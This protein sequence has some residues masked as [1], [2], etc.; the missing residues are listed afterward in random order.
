MKIYQNLRE[1][2]M[3]FN[4]VADHFYKKKILSAIGKIFRG[5]HVHSI[6]KKKS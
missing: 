2:G 6:K 4:Q 5:G 1:K 3:T